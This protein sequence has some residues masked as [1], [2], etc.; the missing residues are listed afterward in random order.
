VKVWFSATRSALFSRQLCG[1][2]QA[3]L[4]L[5]A[6]TSV[7]P[8]AAQAF[9]LP[10]PELLADSKLS[11]PT[12]QLRRLTLR[13]AF[14][15]G[16]SFPTLHRFRLSNPFVSD[17]EVSLPIPQSLYRISGVVF[18]PLCPSGTAA[19][20]TLL[21]YLFDEILSFSCSPFDFELPSSA[22]LF[23]RLGMIV[24]RSPLPSRKPRTLKRPSNLLS[25]PVLSPA[26]SQRSVGGAI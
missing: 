15:S 17:S 14:H 8:V 18:R 26:G 16:V 25:P 1:T 7:L 3:S 24:A 13:F 6:L 9:V 23:T 22:A 20:S 11:F 5:P 19:R 10:L 12:S 2:F 21:A 4:N